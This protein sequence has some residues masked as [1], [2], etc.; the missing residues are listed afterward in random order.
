MIGSSDGVV[1]V[2]NIGS[3]EPLLWLQ[4]Q[5]RLGKVL[6]I[7]FSDSEEQ[8]C[9]VHESGEVC[10]W[11]LDSE[12]L[13]RTW[14]MK[15]GVEVSSAAIH[16]SGR[17]LALASRSP[18][19][20]ELWDVR[21]H[22]LIISYPLSSHNVPSSTSLSFSPDGLHLVCG[23]TGGTLVFELERG[24]LIQT[25][26]DPSDTASTVTALAFHPFEPLLV[27]G[28]S[29][30]K[31]TMFDFTNF[32]N[33][34]LPSHQ[35]S[36]SAPIAQV[37]WSSEGACLM[38][39]SSEHILLWN[40]RRTHAI[41]AVDVLAI[42]SP[43][44][45]SSMASF[46]FDSYAIVLM[47]DDKLLT[48]CYY[49]L[50][51]LGLLQGSNVSP[52]SEEKS[53]KQSSPTSVQTDNDS[54]EPVEDDTLF[55]QLM[56]SKNLYKLRNRLDHLKSLRAT[57]SGKS[58][59]SILASV[60]KQPSAVRAE[61]LGEL[62]SARIIEAALNISPATVSPT[63][64]A[65]PTNEDF[66]TFLLLLKQN[67][68]H[69]TDHHQLA[70]LNYLAQLIPDLAFVCLEKFDVIQDEVAKLA[71]SSTS[72]LVAIKAKEVLVALSSSF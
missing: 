29:S 8:L 38:A 25:L 30:G 69:M 37:S 35:N 32:S 5:E 23:G 4:T 72:S 3:T 40:S 46:G 56:G 42:D 51:S 12:L 22:A 67:I 21:N 39:L 14:K 31:L 41:Q 66:G 54:A 16:P 10:I 57:W 13:A 27:T 6:A 52:P 20:I 36:P 45:K 26:S 11:D 61:L 15:S 65:T 17:V 70:A 1:C 33:L 43:L 55:S 50:Q 68:K 34:E 60:S 58:A 24:S 48:T 59:P 19:Q 63:G 28:S 49:N 62:L 64:L 71:E 2:Y 47:F 7:S 53:E 18:A 9:V 44:A